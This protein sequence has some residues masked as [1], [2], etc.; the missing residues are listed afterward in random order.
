MEKLTKSRIFYII[1]ILLSLII[2]YFIFRKLD[3]S[4]LIENFRHISVTTIIIV[5]IVTIARIYLEYRIWGYYLRINPDYITNKNEIFRSLLI[6]YSLRFLLPGGYAEVGKMYFIDNE[7]KHSFMSIGIE[8]FFQGWKT[9]LFAS[10]AAI[11]YFRQKFIIPTIII[12]VFILLIP[13]I[14]YFVKYFDRKK[15]LISYFEEYKKI[16]PKIFVIQ[17]LLMFTTILQYFLII[18][19]FFRF[20]IF[21]A[22]I[23]IPL[24]M[25][26]SLIPITFAGLGLRETFAIEVLA[27]YDISSEVSVTTALTIFIINLLIPALVGVYFLLKYKKEKTKKD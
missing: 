7:K 3:V 10:F 27:K 4:D 13:F 19:N 22:I 18:N 8:K 24:I 21:S 11:F 16:I 9:I 1:K 25:F 14:L 2:L 20:H 26:F 6:G 5:F 17:I 15:S 12:F 23:S